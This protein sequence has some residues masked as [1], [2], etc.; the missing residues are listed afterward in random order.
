ML[1]DIAFGKFAGAL[2]GGNGQGS[3]IVRLVSEF[4]CYGSD[5]LVGFIH[6]FL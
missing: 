3:L 6:V 4:F 1:F 2:P 5:F